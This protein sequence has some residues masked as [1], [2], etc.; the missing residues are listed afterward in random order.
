MFKGKSGGKNKYFKPSIFVRHLR[1]KYLVLV[2]F[3][4][5]C[6]FKAFSQT[7]DS[8]AV[9]ESAANHLPEMIDIQDL[10]NKRSNKWK[11]EFEGHWSGVEIGV[12]GFANPDYSMYPAEEK[13]F[14]STD[15]IWSN[16]L[17]LN[18]LQFSKGLQSN[19]NT[20][21]LVSGLGLSLQ[22]YRFDDNMSIELDER[23]K[24]QPVSLD[25]DSNEKS[26]LSMVYL[27]VPLLAEFQVP[28]KNKINRLYCSLGINAGAR[29]SSH[30][31]IKYRIDGK[32]Q[33]LK[34]PG[35][36]AMGDFRFAATARVGYGWVN[37]FANYDL[38]PLF[39][40]GRG[41]VL[42]PYSVGVKLISF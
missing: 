6:I 7:N 14:L 17:N 39:E 5:I 18:L 28:F 13:D 11:Q 23:G 20:M 26:K 37:L 12:N 27:Q 30:T 36:Y 41:P 40:D 32:T 38:T 19:R 31:K 8:I 21:G 22:S 25:F 34:T 33:K 16:V 15:L 9:S 29:L 42:Y 35:D 3:T 2:L 24:L 10:V 1:M 4:F